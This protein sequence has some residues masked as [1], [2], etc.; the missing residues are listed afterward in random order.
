MSGYQG[1]PTQCLI[2]FSATILRNSIEENLIV[3]AKVGWPDGR[4]LERLS[5]SA[6]AHS[7]RWIVL[8][9]VDLN[10]HAFVLCVLPN[11]MDSQILHWMMQ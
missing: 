1:T 10:S 7:S 4:S 6:H 5:A 8:Y 2:D 3:G 11:S 9:L